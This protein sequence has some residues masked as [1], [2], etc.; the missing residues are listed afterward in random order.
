MAIIRKNDTVQVMA[1]DDAG[2]RGRVLEVLPK[3][4]RV[5]VAGI[6][7]V[8]RHVRPSQ[9]HPRGGRLEKEMPLSISNVML[10]CPRCQ[11]PARVRLDRSQEG[12]VRRMCRRCGDSLDR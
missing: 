7:Y 10:V 5:L 9:K 12:R 4:G 1:G 6:N 2:K 8:Q 3:K 11:K